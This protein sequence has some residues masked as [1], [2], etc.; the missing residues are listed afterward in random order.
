MIKLIGSEKQ[1]KWAEELREQIIKELDKVEMGTSIRGIGK[2]EVDAELIEATKNINQAKFWINSRD[3]SINNILEDAQAILDAEAEKEFALE[4]TNKVN[5]ELIKHL[6]FI[7]KAYKEIENEEIESEMLEVKELLIKTL[8][9]NKTLKDFTEIVD[10]M[11]EEEEDKDDS[12]EDLEEF[13][14]I[15]AYEMER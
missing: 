12:N 3:L 8:D 1:V 2:N 13:Y 6:L 11:L 14:Y 9:A 4:I 15:I 7:T 5:D 10:E